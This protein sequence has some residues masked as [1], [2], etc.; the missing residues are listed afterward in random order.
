MIIQ[1]DDEEMMTMNEGEEPA[2][3][4]SLSSRRYSC[5]NGDVLKI[6]TF[7][8]QISGERTEREWLGGASM[9]VTVHLSVPS[10]C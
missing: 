8:R 1:T 3:I 6:E 2:N 7:H 4:E 9:A 10:V 5:G